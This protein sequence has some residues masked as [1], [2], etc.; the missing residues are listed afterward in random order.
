MVNHSNR[1]LKKC[2][3]NDINLVIGN[4]AEQVRKATEDRK[5]YLFYTG[6][7]AWN[8]SCYCMCQGL[9]KGQG[10]N[11]G[12][13]HGRCSFDYRGNGKKFF[14]FHEEGKHKATILNSPS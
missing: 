3:I 6:R 9:F 2:D 4:G 11:C 8:R 7:A 5:C 13:I 14:R 10:W 1:Y 12:C